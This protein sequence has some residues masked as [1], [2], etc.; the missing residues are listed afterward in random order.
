MRDF[1]LMEYV[2]KKI[3]LSRSDKNCNISKVISEDQVQNVLDK[4]Y[5]VLADE[6]VLLDVAANIHVVGDLHGNIDDLLRIFELLGYPPKERYIFLGDYVD[7]GTNS[8][9]VMTL[10][11]AFKVKFPSNIYLLRGNH[12]IEHVSKCYGFL[13]EI[14]SKYS[15]ALFYNFQ[16]VFQ[17][18]PIIGIV[19]KR[20]LCVHGGIGPSMKDV[21]DFRKR[22]KPDEITETSIF[23][24]IVWSDPRNMS[25]EFERNPRGC[26]WTF[27]VQATRKFLIKNDL[28]LIL[29]SHESYDG[30]S[31]PFP[32]DE[33]ITV[34]SNTDYCDKKNGGAIINVSNNL[35]V[36]VTRFSLMSPEEK[37]KWR[38]V[39]PPWL[40]E[41]LNS[42]SEET[43][44]P[45]SEIDLVHDHASDCESKSIENTSSKDALLLCS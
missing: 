14:I 33:C 38:P 37:S 44:E 21:S 11:F 32:T 34:F 1:D 12:E 28:D 36:T 9:E 7:R 26:G 2:I 23:A 39:L 10:L 27:N 20:I 18:L 31:F 29:R 30:Y 25:N 4:A 17:Q 19:G 3:I 16:K 13:D 40:I 43:D 45:K 35:N 15:T 5:S 24:D 8:F 6:P 22:L 41:K 42:K